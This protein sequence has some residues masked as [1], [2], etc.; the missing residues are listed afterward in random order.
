[1]LPNVAI[2]FMYDNENLSDYDMMICK[3]DSN[4]GLETVSVGN[5]LTFNTIKANK[6]DKSYLTSIYYEE[7]LST[8]F[9][10]CKKNCRKEDLAISSEELTSLLRWLSRRDGYHKFEFYQEGYE[11]VFF[12]GSFNNVQ[13]LKI[14]GILYGLELTF[15]T[16]SPYAYENINFNFTTSAAV[17]YNLFNLSNE[18]GHLYPTV[19][20]CKC[21]SNGDLQIHNSIEDRTTKIANCINGEI[22]TIDGNNKIIESS[23]ITHNLYNDFNYNYFRL[24]NTYDN[25]LNIIT[26]SLPCDIAIEYELIRKVGLG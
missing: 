24:A 12:Y 21:L 1:M 4:S 19:F 6:S 11:G 16:D 17:G 23:V 26:T 5:N 20:S 22:I 3:F 13:Q 8:T 25:N 2:D 7:P 10:I 9:Q 14:G 18:T 15:V